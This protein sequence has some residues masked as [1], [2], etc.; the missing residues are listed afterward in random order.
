MTPVLASGPPSR[1][2]RIRSRRGPMTLRARRGCATLNSSS[3]VA[4]EDRAADADHAGPTSSTGKV[5]HLGAG[6]RDEHDQH[7]QRGESDRVVN[8]CKCRDETD[9]PGYTVFTRGKQAAAGCPDLCGLTPRT[10]SVSL[11]TFTCAPQPSSPR[12]SIRPLAGS[13]SRC[14]CAGGIG[15]QLKRLPVSS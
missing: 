13:A 4:V 11:S 8:A 7:D 1:R 12:P 14:A 5:A 6:A 3:L 2:A 15:A 10:G 9:L